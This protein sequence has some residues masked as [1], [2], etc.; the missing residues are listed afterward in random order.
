MFFCY[1]NDDMIES[2]F[3]L[4]QMAATAA[5]QVDPFCYASPEVAVAYFLPLSSRFQEIYGGGP[6]YTFELN[7]KTWHQLYT[8]ASV[9]Y[10]CENGRSIGAN[11]TTNIQLIPL[12]FGF[13]YLWWCTNSHPYIAI[14]PLFT[15]FKTEDNAPF[16]IRKNKKWGYGATA[17]VG[18]SWYIWGDLCLDVFVNYSYMYIDFDRVPADK[19]VVRHDADLSGFSF[20][21]GLGYSF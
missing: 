12:A 6:I 9:S 21:S 18:N 11:N 8:W 10:F 15:R 7:V 20:G 1:L 3:F 19:P 5:A 17:K 14:G 16:V 4:G 2:L 13:K